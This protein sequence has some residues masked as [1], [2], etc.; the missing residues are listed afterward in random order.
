MLVMGV[1]GFALESLGFPVVP[2]V[3]GLVLGPLVEQNFMISLIK[4]EGYLP[5]F[6]S[7]PVSLV[8]AG[9]TFVVWAL[10]LVSWI[11]TRLGPGVR[12]PSAETISGGSDA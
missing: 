1:L 3:L 4:S 6:V 10:P 12:E 8:L 7:R 5:A 11:R 9:L 2:V